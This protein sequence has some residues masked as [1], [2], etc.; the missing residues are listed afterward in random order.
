MYIHSTYVSAGASKNS[1]KYVCKL[2]N[3]VVHIYCNLHCI[4]ITAVAIT[5]YG[6]VVNYNNYK[7]L[8][9][10]HRTNT[11]SNQS[12]LQLLY[13]IIITN[14]IALDYYLLRHSAY[15]IFHRGSS[16]MTSH[17][18]YIKLP[19]IVLGLLVYFVQLC[20]YD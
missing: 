2:N 9:I 4:S 16:K 3:L 20:G 13:A 1:L 17:K 11:T 8:T 14:K 12:T 10:Y 6:C 5:A 19:T 7:Y 15:C 18:M